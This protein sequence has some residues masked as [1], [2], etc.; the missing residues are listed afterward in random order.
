MKK[1]LISALALFVVGSVAAE[2]L[3]ETYNKAV[4]AY[5]SKDFAS[6]ATAFET[7]I[8]QGLDSEDLDVQS[9][10]ATAKKSVPVC[11]FQ[12]GLTAAKGNDFNTA[13]EN[14]TKSANKAA[15]YGELQQERMSNMLMAKIYLM[16]GGKPFNEKNYAEAAE[17]FAKGYA[18]D[19]K[20]MEMA[21]FL[22]ICYCE[23]GDFQKGLVIFNEIASQDNPKYAEDVVKAK[24]N[25]KLY[26]NNRIAKL[27]GE[28]D[29]DGIIAVADEMLAV[30]PQDA[31]AQ[32]IR[33]QALFDKK[34]YAG[35]IASAEEAAAGQTDE[36]ERSDVYFILGA[37]YNARTM[38]QQA[39]DALSKVTPVRMWLRH[40][41]RWH[42]LRRTQPKRTVSGV[43]LFLK[44]GADFFGSLPRFIRKG[45][46]FRDARGGGSADG[47]ALYRGGSVVGPIQEEREPLCRKSGR[48][49]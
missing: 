33:L 35:V 8:D 16:W 23:L 41:K 6:A 9:W 21:N 5:N 14:L 22:G 24:E 43:F 42:S 40:R 47:F 28:N 38:P 20:N 48:W 19:P 44:C 39:I 31:L 11:Y 46:D 18:A 25:I 15:L 45:F 36:E 34:D 7:L 49:R 12:M 3:G 27:Q 32:K 29:F 13:V 17:I 37:A 1:L 26:T 4:A 2:G 10:V 30:N